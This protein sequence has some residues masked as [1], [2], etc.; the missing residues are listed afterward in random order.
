MTRVLL[1][2]TGLLMVWSA[3]SGRS[4]ECDVPILVLAILA[5]ASVVADAIRRLED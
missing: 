3:V 2:A 5:G 4:E 1:V